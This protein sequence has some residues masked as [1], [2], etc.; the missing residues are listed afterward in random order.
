MW[1]MLSLT[2]LMVAMLIWNRWRPDVIALAV[3][4]I[5]GIMHVIPDQWLFAGF[6]SRMNLQI[7]HSLTMIIAITTVHR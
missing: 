2:A 3:L 7:Q 5:L 1:A 6:S 4:A